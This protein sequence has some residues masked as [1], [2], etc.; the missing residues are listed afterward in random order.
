M[1]EG[2]VL[3]PSWKPKE[4]V[5]HARIWVGRED[6]WKSLDIEGNRKFGREVATLGCRIRFEGRLTGVR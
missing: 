3:A 2:V 4:V 1:L 6:L 5:K